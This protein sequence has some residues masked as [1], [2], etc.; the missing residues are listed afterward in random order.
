ML[1]FRD[2]QTLLALKEFVAVESEC[3]PFFK[4]S[5]GSAGAGP[6]LDVSAPEGGEEAIRPLVAGFVSG[7]GNIESA[8]ECSC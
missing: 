5:I 4:F 3:C 1:R 2:D 7:W 6:T 8:R